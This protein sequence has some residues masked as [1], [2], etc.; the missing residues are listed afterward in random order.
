M[1]P[2]SS[3]GAEDLRVQRTRKFLWEALL[4]L[5]EEK[6]FEQIS[7]TD[8][9]TRAMVHRTTFYKHYQDKTELLDDGIRQMLE[10]LRQEVDRALDSE[11]KIRLTYLFSYVAKHSRF[12]ALMLSKEGVSSFQTLLR[13]VFA[14][15]SEVK[16][17]KLIQP[18]REVVA[19][20]T[21]MAQFWAGALI[22]TLSWW[23]ENQMPYS[24]DEMASYVSGFLIAGL[25]P[26]ASS[27]EI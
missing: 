7:I 17:Q 6:S 24:S 13:Q 19:P 22:A 21:V 3:V 8:I 5:L 10:G 2:N 27:D 25:Y 23:L 16:L 26:F 4:S 14:E 1:L 18:S 12:Y 20:P 11:P 9:C 15:R